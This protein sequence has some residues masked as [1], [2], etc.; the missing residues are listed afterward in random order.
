MPIILKTNRLGIIKFLLPFFIVLSFFFVVLIG[1]YIFDYDAI[2]DQTFALVTFSSLEGIF[3]I[4]FLCVKFI[5]RRTYKFTDESIVVLKK[6]QAVKEIRIE[7]IL[8]LTYKK[9]KVRYV[10]SVFV[11][12][13]QDGGCWKLYLDMA[14]G[15]RITLDI[16]DVK[17]V[18]KLKDLYGDLVQIS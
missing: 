14:N 17:D 12:E 4:G 6:G 3:V 5:K 10:F 18:Q 8:S 16:F 2:K 7:N 9:F 11:G 13:L 15:S 1:C